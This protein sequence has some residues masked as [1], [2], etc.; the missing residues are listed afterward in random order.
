MRITKKNRWGFIDLSWMFIQPVVLP[1]LLYY[2][3]ILCY[4]L[5]YIIITWLLLID[6]W[7][8]CFSRSVF[9]L[10]IIALLCPSKSEISLVVRERSSQLIHL[11]NCCSI[12]LVYTKVCS[13]YTTNIRLNCYFTSSSTWVGV[14]QNVWFKVEILGQASCF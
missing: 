3:S 4:K 14:L 11:S 7:E 12:V 13:T 2:W 9:K 6:R 10:K 8:K 5:L 1:D